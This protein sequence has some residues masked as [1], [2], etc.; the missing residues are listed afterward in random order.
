LCIF[1]RV[2]RKIHCLLFLLRSCVSISPES[3]VLLRRS[4]HRQR[5]LGAKATVLTAVLFGGILLLTLL[6]E[7]FLYHH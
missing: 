1:V 5:I 2:R 7:Y 4:L 6:R 3:F